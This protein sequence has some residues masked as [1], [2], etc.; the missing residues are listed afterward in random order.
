MLE[1]GIIIESDARDWAGLSWGLFKLWD[2]NTRHPDPSTYPA[3]IRVD[4]REG[5]VRTYV[6][7][8]SCLSSSSVNVP[9][10]KYV[11]R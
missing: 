9:G 1:L 5:R 3:R 10:V 4:K 2:N 7:T 8:L 11:L 6:P